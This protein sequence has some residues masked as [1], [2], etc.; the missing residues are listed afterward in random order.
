M[1]GH[2]F[3]VLTKRTGL[4]ASHIWEEITSLGNNVHTNTQDENSNVDPEGVGE[5]S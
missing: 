3:I 1:D 5:M 4:V 2:K